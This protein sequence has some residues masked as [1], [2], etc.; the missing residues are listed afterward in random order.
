MIEMISVILGGIGVMVAAVFAWIANRAKE[1]AQE[2]ITR[3]E[4]AEMQAKHA[5][6]AVTAKSASI[7]AAQAVP[8]KR[9]RRKP[10]ADDFQRPK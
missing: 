7:E 6:H 3:A 8:K 2:A 10:K 5:E 9:V 4:H 1:T